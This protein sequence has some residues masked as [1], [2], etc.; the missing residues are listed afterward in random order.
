MGAGLFRTGAK[1]S[2]QN[3]L[4]RHSTATR[5]PNRPTA[6]DQAN[7][8]VARRREAV[9]ADLEQVPLADHDLSSELVHGVRKRI[10]LDF[11]VA[12]RLDVAYRKTK[13]GH[14][15]TSTGD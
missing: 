14:V 11:A 12:P 6:L 10:T 1:R 7:A 8:L 15:D 9:H 13:L 5:E 3:A 2:T 4:R